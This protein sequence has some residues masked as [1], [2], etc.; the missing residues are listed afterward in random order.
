MDYSQQQQQPSSQQNQTGGGLTGMI[1]NMLSPTSNQQRSPQ[2]QQQ[3]Q[4]QQPSSSLTSLVTG[5]RTCGK[6][7]ASQSAGTKFCQSCGVPTSLDVR[8]PFQ[9]AVPVQLSMSNSAEY[10]PEA[11]DT[12]DYESAYGCG[13][14]CFRAGPIVRE[15]RWTIPENLYIFGLASGGEI[16]MSIGEFIHPHTTVNVAMF[17]GS[18]K[19]KLP[20]G[21]RVDVGGLGLCGTFASPDTQTVDASADVPLISITGVSVW[22]TVDV[23][24]DL[25]RPVLTIVR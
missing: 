24:V 20:P 4:Q 16:D 12:S 3:Q 25:T 22:S 5:G 1:S 2:Q 17:C 23:K 7:G 8:A 9:Q 10:H 15:G 13:V 19:I 14:T 21:V 6:C 11:V 18:L